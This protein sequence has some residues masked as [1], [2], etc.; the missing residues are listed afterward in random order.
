[1]PR[2]YSTY[3]GF[4][5]DIG[6]FEHV[7]E[8]LPADFT[9]VYEIARILE[10]ETSRI[11]A[12][13]QP[14]LRMGSSPAVRENEAPESN[15]YDIIVD[16]NREY[17]TELIRSPQHLP[18]IYNYQWLLPEEVFY[19]KLAKKELWVP[20]YKSPTYHSVEPD[21]ESYSPDYRKQNVYILLD[22]SASMATK[23]RI[24]LARAITYLFLKRNMREM[25]YISLRTFDEEISELQTARDFA[26]FERLIR[27]VM[28][29]QALG[30]GTAMTK[31]IETAVH[32]I[33]KMQQFAGT[34][35][36][37]VTDGACSLDE[38][39][40]RE[41]LG[42]DIVIHTVKIGK[43]QVFVSESY[44]ED[45]LFHENT[46]EHRKV[47]A[48]QR[49]LKDLRRLRDKEQSSHG[50]RQLDER[51]K[52]GEEELAQQIHEFKQDISTG[53]GRE[54]EHL[55]RV[56][57]EVPDIDVESYIGLDE[58]ALRDLK[59]LVESLARTLN[60]RSNVENLKRL[61]LL[62]D[63]LR[64][65]LNHTDDQR[66]KS[67]L[68]ELLK[69]ASERIQEHTKPQVFGG[70]T[71][72]ASRIGNEDRNDLRFMLGIAQEGGMSLLRMLIIRIKET[73]SR[74]AKKIFRL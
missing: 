36:L 66:I 30:N 58:R 69:Y 16:D 52:H 10:D 73:L 17:E 18:R 57:L 6:Y 3:L 51:I 53:Y 48:M 74:A 13:L 42:D 5:E 27:F 8:E 34:E 49:V 55:S 20:Y 32:D 23:N 12:M 56:Y 24:D 64:F 45:K 19:R 50:R 15:E 54:L 9:A 14:A 7:Y 43:S 63:H 29:H 33:R 47:A 38:D 70:Q 61:A 59:E 2:A 67:A 28:R 68:E 22:T 62:S 25:G 1:M 39:A 35:I 41:M 37:I 31:A 72:L 60:E 46:P 44:L 26:S 4:M 40:M 11:G 21:D 65:L 71:G